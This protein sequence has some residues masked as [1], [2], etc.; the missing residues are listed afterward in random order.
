MILFAS[1]AVV[2]SVQDEGVGIPTGDLPYVFELFR[3]G[4]NV[5]DQI[6]GTGIG[7]MSSRQTV[8]Q[9][10][11][12]IVVQSREGRGTTFAIRLPLASAGIEN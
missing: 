8:E 4:A 2:L 7:L 3:R 11:G 12:S 6:P 1:A 9:H 10:G 5:A